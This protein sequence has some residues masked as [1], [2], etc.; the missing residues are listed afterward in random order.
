[1]IMFGLGFVC[2]WFV[3]AALVYFIDGMNGGIILFDRWAV[4]ALL[5]PFIPFVILIEW[6]QEKAGKL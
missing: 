4:Y 3:F 6:I 1:M 2:A 5:L